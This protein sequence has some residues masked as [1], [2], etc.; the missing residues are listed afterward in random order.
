MESVEI[1]RPGDKRGT[2]PRFST[3]HLAGA[4]AESTMSRIK[5]RPRVEDDPTYWKG[6]TPLTVFPD[7]L[8]ARIAAQ[9]PAKM[10]EAKR[11]ILTRGLRFVAH[12][13]IQRGKNPSPNSRKERGRAKADLAQIV[14]HA[15]AL[16]LALRKAIETNSRVWCELMGGDETRFSRRDA[17]IWLIKEAAMPPRRFDIKGKT[18]ELQRGQL[19]ASVRDMADAWGWGK[20]AVERF[21]TRL[22]T[23]TMIGTESET[24]QLVITIC[25]YDKHQLTGRD[26]GTAAGR[27]ELIGDDTL[28]LDDVAAELLTTHQSICRLEDRARLRLA[29]LEKLP[30]RGRPPNTDREIVMNFFIQLYKKSTGLEAGRTTLTDTSQSPHQPAGD[31]YKFAQPAWEALYGDVAGLDDVIKNCLCYRAKG[32]L[33]TNL[34]QPL[35]ENPQMDV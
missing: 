26:T 25:N 3:D 8:I 28:S 2:A 33:G 35:S 19:T 18:V 27:C 11:D 15:E 23:E 1:A 24:G 21:I 6:K 34:I 7:E 22:K 5:I 9:L 32:L 14:E 13:Q 4:H 29:D 17:W 16:E 10:N 12:V 20:H 31:F 30:R